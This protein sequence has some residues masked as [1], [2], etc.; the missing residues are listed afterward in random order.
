MTAAGIVWG[1]AVT[2][3]NM[4]MISLRQSVIPD[5]LLGR[6]SATIRMFAWSMVPVGA[7]GGG[8]LASAVNA[9]AT[10]AAGAASLRPRGALHRHQPHPTRRPRRDLTPCPP[11]IGEGG[12]HR[13][14]CV[15]P[16]GRKSNTSAARAPP[17]GKGDRG[18][19]LPLQYRHELPAD[20]AAAS[21]RDALDQPG[22]L[23]HRRSPVRHRSDL[24]RREGRRQRRRAGRGGGSVAT[25]AF[26]LFGGV[27]A[28]RWDRQRTMA[29]VDLL[30]GAA[31]LV[32]PVLAWRSDA[33]T[34][35]S[36]RGRGDRWRT[37]CAFRSRAASEPP[38]SGTRPADLTG[39]ERPDGY[40][41]AARP[42]H[43]PEPRGCARRD[44]AALQLFVLDTVSFV[45]SAAA[46]L[47]LGRRFAWKPERLA[48]HRGGIARHR[49]R[50]RGRGADGPCAIARLRGH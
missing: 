49:Q 31:V 17:R 41:P 37:G 21:S 36:W 27:Y 10:L 40:D 28:D 39:N 9:R 48:T 43:R 50:D 20:V 14:S 32:L 5:H 16:C 7:I 6:A 19:G 29:A 12:T 45:I 44:P 47:S 4:P 15:I 38:R 46:V 2:L 25:L 23:R 1:S 8:L 13:E 11:S 33:A 34:L 35:A 30:R 22:S 42:R 18:L 26:G 3:M 24:D